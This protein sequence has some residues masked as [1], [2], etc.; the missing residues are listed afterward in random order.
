MLIANHIFKEQEV[1]EWT[2]EMEE[3]S[4]SVYEEEEEEISAGRTANKRV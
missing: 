2:E 3:V 4:I 1:E